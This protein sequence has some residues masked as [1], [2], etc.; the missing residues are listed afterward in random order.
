M[1]KKVLITV[2]AVVVLVAIAVG[3]YFMF[4][5]AKTVTLDLA[6]ISEN[7]TNAGFSKMATMNIDK[8]VLSTSFDVNT[9]NV[10]EV[11]GKM[12]MMNVHA[13]MYILIKAKA[14]TVETVKQD[15]EAYGER[16]EQQ[17]AMYLPNQHELVQNR[18]IGVMGDY[19][20]MVIAENADELV[21]LIK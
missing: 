19:V 9:E 8:D 6:T 2:I 1:D 12:P 11:Y 5:G 7:I 13:S 4:K 16:Y 17:W 15:I 21:S 18:K 3:A 20:Y 14:G 10:E